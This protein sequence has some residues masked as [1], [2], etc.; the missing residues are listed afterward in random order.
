MTCGFKDQ[1]EEYVQNGTKPHTMRQ[2]KRWKVGMR[3]DAF[4]RPRQKGM[5]LL[6]RAIITRVDDV[7]VWHSIDP[8]I[9]VAININGDLLDRDDTERFLWVDGFRDMSRGSSIDQALSFWRKQLA[10]GAWE[11]QIVHWNPAERFMDVAETY[12]R[13]SKMMARGNLA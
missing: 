4:V 2:G 13:T 1:F 5:R 8:R 7:L 6:F 10:A 11:G 12:N 9:A 3:L